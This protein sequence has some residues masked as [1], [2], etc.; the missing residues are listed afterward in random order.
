[1]RRLNKV[2]HI[3]NQKHLIVRVSTNQIRALKIG[4]I[5]VTKNLT[6][7]GR[8]FDIF[9]PVNQPYISIQLN[10]EIKG[11]E[12]LVGE[13]IYSFEEKKSQKRRKN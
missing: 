4:Q 8:I 9:G 12:R 11:E 10:P 3:S 6:K 5:I 7:L 2:L 1:M 13:I